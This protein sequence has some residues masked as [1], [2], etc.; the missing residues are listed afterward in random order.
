MSIPDQLLNMKTY[1]IS[2]LS[3]FITKLILSPF[4]IFLFGI[5]LNSEIS[6]LMLLIVLDYI[7]GILASFQRNIPITSRKSARTLAKFF[8]FILAIAASHAL[9]RIIYGELYLISKVVIAYLATNEFLSVVENFSYMGYKFPS[10]LL[11]RIKD[12][13]KAL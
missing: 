11:R 3:N 4:Y 6:G 5:N 12:Y 10:K 13:E 8:V 7:T 1:I 9:E 2:S